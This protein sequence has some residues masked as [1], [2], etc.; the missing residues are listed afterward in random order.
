MC[1]HGCAHEL[2]GRALW[3]AVA[4]PVTSTSIT[5]APSIIAELDSAPDVA[6]IP[7]LQIHP[8]R[9]APVVFAK[10]AIDHDIR[11]DSDL[12]QRLYARELLVEHIAGEAD[13]H[14][15]AQ[16]TGVEAGRNQG[17]DA[18]QDLIAAHDA[19]RQV[20]SKMEGMRAREAIA[21][22][23]ATTAQFAERACDRRVDEPDIVALRPVDYK[24]A[25]HD[26]GDLVASCRARRNCY[27]AAS[28]GCSAG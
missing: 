5:R 4:W 2:P 10:V 25:A 20:P 18:A 14:V 9:V 12:M 28:S 16:V 7:V 27:R 24:S 17:A 6:I 21:G 26:L 8:P 15:K 3:T 13:E 11:F 22:E 19:D 23:L 1:A